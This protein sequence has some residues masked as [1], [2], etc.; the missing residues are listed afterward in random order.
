MS[1]IVMVEVAVLGLLSLAALGI[2][3]G[4]AVRPSQRRYEMLRPVTVAMVFGCLWI[5][6]TGLTNMLMGLASQHWTGDLVPRVFAGLA[7]MLVPS[8]VAM[9]VLTVAWGLSAIGMR[10]LD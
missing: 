4:M 10:R 2:G 7:E 3:L 8:M 9:A 1:P 6:G 5:S